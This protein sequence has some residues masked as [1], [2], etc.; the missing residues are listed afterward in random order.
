MKLPRTVLHVSLPD[1]TFQ[2]IKQIATDER[3]PQSYIARE[4][5]EESLVARREAAIPRK[6]AR[7]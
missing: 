3:R 6:A 1:D 7:R 2:R 4:L 5:I